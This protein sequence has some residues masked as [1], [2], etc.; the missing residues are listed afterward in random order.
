MA[1]HGGVALRHAFRQELEVM[2]SSPTKAAGVALGALLACGC[3]NSPSQQPD[4][5]PSWQRYEVLGSRI[6]R[7]VDASGQPTAASYTVT[8]SGAEWARM[9]AVS[10]KKKRR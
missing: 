6:T 2:N 9:P 4:R 3:A 1:R 5:T 7:R 10:L 8:T